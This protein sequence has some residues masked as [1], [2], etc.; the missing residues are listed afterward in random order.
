[1]TATRMSERESDTRE[2][3][4]Y[5]LN[6]TRITNDYALSSSPVLIARLSAEINY[7]GYLRTEEWRRVWGPSLHPGT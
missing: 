6:I 4:W 2:M 1:M 5:N 3:G 7:G